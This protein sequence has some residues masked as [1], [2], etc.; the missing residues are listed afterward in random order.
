MGAKIRRYVLG[1]L[2]VVPLFFAQAAQSQASMVLTNGVGTIG[3]D[4]LPVD[5]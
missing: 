2:M 1:G 5:G 4:G 3:I